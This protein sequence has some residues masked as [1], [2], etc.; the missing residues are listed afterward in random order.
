MAEQHKSEGNEVTA[1]GIV[2]R[3]SCGWVSRACFSNMIASSLGMAHREA[4]SNTG[5][6]GA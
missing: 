5:E 6:S 2:H 4:Q 3:C 1:D